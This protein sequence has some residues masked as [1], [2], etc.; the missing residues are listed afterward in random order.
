[1]TKKEFITTAI[2]A[3]LTVILSQIWIYAFAYMVKY[4]S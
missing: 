4:Y 2:L 1:M 3:I